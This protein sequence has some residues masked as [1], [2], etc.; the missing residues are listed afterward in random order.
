VRVVRQPARQVVG[1]VQ[2]R[3]HRLLEARLF[4][5]LRQRASFPPGR[6]LRPQAVRQVADCGPAVR[7]EHQYIP[8]AA[9]TPPP[10]PVL[11]QPAPKSP[12]STATTCRTPPP[13]RP[14]RRPSTPARWTPTRRIPT[15]SR[16]RGN[17]S[18]SVP[19]IRR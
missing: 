4:A 13:A 15:F 1:G 3:H 14:G 17:T 9:L 12:G 19:F 7:L 10:L 6:R 8:P 5:R 2:V 11:P 18:I 16:R